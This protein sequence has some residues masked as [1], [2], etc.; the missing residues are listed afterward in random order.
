MVI[1]YK[2]MYTQILFVDISGA[3]CYSSE[4]LAS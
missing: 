2:Y 4:L 3:L 1:S